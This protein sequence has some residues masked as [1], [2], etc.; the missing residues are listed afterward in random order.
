[1]RCPSQRKLTLRP[2][3]GGR[4]ASGRQ[5]YTKLRKPGLRL[6]VGGVAGAYRPSASAGALQDVGSESALMQLKPSPVVAFS[7]WLARWVRGFGRSIRCGGGRPGYRC[8]LLPTV[9]SL[10]V[11]MINAMTRNYLRFLV[12]RIV[13]NGTHGELYARTGAAVRVMV[14]GQKRRRR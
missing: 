3:R 12:D 8:V 4:Q 13:L 1:V 6:L 11:D 7:S 2:S 5:W 14:S 9:V 10:V